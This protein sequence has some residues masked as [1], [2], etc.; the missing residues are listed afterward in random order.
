MNVTEYY[1]L[2]LYE[3]GYSADPS[4]RAAVERLQG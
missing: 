1:E 2:S 3:R 4:Q